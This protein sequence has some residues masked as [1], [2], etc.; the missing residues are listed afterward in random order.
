MR[1]VKR[2]QINRRTGEALADDGGFSAA[3]FVELRSR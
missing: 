3:G 2:L 1:K